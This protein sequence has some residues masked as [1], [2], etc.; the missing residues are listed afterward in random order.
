M[1]A[2][3]LFALPLILALG[4]PGPT[5]KPD[6]TG[7]DTAVDCDGD[8][9]GFCADVDCDDSDPDVHPDVVEET[10]PPDSVDNDCDGIIDECSE[11]DP[12]L[13]WHAEEVCDGID[14]DCDGEVDEELG[15]TWYPDEDGDG[16]GD[17]RFPQESCDPD[18]GLVQ[19]DSDCDDEDATVNP[20]AQ[21]TC[22]GVDDDCDSTTIED[23]LITIEGV[24]NQASIQDALSGVDEGGTITVCPGSYEGTYTI[25]RGLTLHAPLGAELT[26]LVS[27]G[28]ASV[29]NVAAGDVTISGFTVSGGV[30]T[31]IST[32]TDTTGGGGILGWNADA[33]TV[34]DCIITGNQADYGGGVMGPGEGLLTIVRSTISSNH[35]DAYGGG[36]YVLDGVIEAVDF[37]DNSSATSGGGLYHFENSLTLADSSFTDNAATY[38]GGIRAYAGTI[39]A[40]STVLEDNQA[41]YGGGLYMR[42]DPTV[43]GLEIR[44]NSADRGAGVYCR[45]D[46][47]LMDTTVEANVATSYG[48]GVMCSSGVT[49][50][51]NVTITDS[52]APGGAGMLLDTCELLLESVTIS[53]GAASYG[54]GVY[55]VDSELEAGADVVVSGNTATSAG[56]GAYV[57]SNSSWDGGEV[58]GNVSDSGAG[59][60]LY[61]IGVLDEVTISGNVAGEWGGGIMVVS[62]S[63]FE[64]IVLDGNE[65]N[66]GG[67]MYVY[68]TGEVSLSSSTITGNI[69]T[70]RGGGI[71]VSAGLLDI[72]ATEFGAAKASN[73]PDDIYAGGT[74]YTGLGSVETLS[75]SGSDGCD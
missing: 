11:D 2:R 55:L 44:G 41:D 10:M 63:D 51:D 52:E 24:G 19:D 69:A 31:D 53:G 64:D 40:S 74:A 71:R 27:D 15:G 28:T 50:L 29:I 66:Y 9:D 46:G 12:E 49:L 68:G 14:N 36:V 65:A 8:G 13:T 58:S 67:G 37:I 33:L 59:L 18:A 4:C 54:G 5:D 60:Y 22:N 6:D 70:E 57:Y 72:A 34:E 73:D 75:C 45:E 7:G 16:Y 23:G 56:G 61:G 21:E 3:L 32:D 47:T 42:N 17:A 43:S 30:G 48:G 62:E 20:G 38:G 1:S 35:A 26:E 25:A 39:E